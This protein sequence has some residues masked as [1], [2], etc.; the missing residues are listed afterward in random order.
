MSRHIRRANK[1]L[2]KSLQA[3]HAADQVNDHYK[4]TAERQLEHL[5]VRKRRLA[6]DIDEG[7]MPDSELEQIQDEYLEVCRQ[8]ALYQNASGVSDTLRLSRAS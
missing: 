4:Q 6:R 1:I 8:I 3:E 2:A 7:G 5:Q